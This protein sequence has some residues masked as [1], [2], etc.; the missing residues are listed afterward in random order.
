[1][2]TVQS[3]NKR[4]FICRH[5][6]AFP[7][8]VGATGGA[9]CRRHELGL[10]PVSCAMTPERLANVLSHKSNANTRV[11][12]AASLF[13]ATPALCQD[14]HR[15][16]VGRPPIPRS[17]ASPQSPG[18][19]ANSCASPLKGA[20]T[21][22]VIWDIAS[23]RAQ[24]ESWRSK[25]KRQHL[26]ISPNKTANKTETEEVVSVGVGPLA[27]AGHRHWAGCRQPHNTIHTIKQEQ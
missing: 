10:T 15:G 17:E 12:F 18:V 1:M 9:L 14:H 5:A 27:G 20:I 21:V 11:I 13:D 3:N 2:H 25:D 23:K 7:H 26:A 24:S 6:K 4:I 16:S 19:W 22:C 8:H